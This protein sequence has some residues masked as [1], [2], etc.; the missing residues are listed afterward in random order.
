MKSVL[1]IGAGAAGLAAAHD[2]ATAGLSVTVLEARERIGGRV[3]TQHDS[4]SPVPIE[5]GAEFVHGRHPALIKLLEESAIPF[6]DVTDRHWYNEGGK[7]RSSHEFWNEL[8]ALMDL[9]S[10]DEPD[11]TFKDFLSSLP[12]NEAVLQASQ[13]A[14]LFVQGFHAANVDQFGVH[15]LIRANKAE[16]EI[17]GDHSFRILGG[18]DRVMEALH[19][20]AVASG[21]I[22][23]LNTLVKEIRWSTD[24]VE[25]ICL[26]GERRQIFSAS[27]IL[28]TLPIGVL[29]SNPDESGAVRFLPQLPEEKRNAIRQLVMGPAFRVTLQFRERFW[30]SLPA[31]EGSVEKDFSQLGFIHDPDAPI[32]TWWSLLHMR[33]PELVGW[34]GGPNAR[35]IEELSQDAILNET[36]MSLHKIF[37][38]SE[39]ALRKLLVSLHTHNWTSDPFSRGA[40][41]YLPVNGLQAQQALARP[42]EDVLFFAGEATS[43]GYVGTV[44]GAIESGQRAA[45]EILEKI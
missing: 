15:G 41:C 28:V 32:P 44:H 4:N 34:S 33:A 38:I 7:T 43:V 2:L 19:A 36:L 6:C 8:N 26:S 37:G 30:E 1:I 17:G 21:T 27:C 20:R 29:Q 10:S 24:R 31:P 11:Q 42:V 23:R 3:F 5:L 9:M 39:W 13:V 16:D 40:Y 25:V 35:R 45:R 22:F 18:Y 12:D 14:T